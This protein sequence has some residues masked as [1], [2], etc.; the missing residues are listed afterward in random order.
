[1]ELPFQST[2]ILM[3]SLTAV[4]VLFHNFTIMFPRK[5]GQEWWDK[6]SKLVRQMLEL[7]GHLSHQLY[8]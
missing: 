1:M 2:D 3:R 7:V 6:S 4:M 8:S 5:S